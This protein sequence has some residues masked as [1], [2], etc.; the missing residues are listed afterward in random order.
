[1]LEKRTWL[2]SQQINKFI[3]ALTS[4]DATAG[5]NANDNANIS[6]NVDI[7]EVGKSICTHCLGFYAFVKKNSDL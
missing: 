1:M 7:V 5:T 6:V 2:P 3:T 4:R